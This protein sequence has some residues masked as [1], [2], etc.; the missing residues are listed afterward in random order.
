MESFRFDA[1][2]RTFPITSRR[3]AARAL[4]G[5]A[6]TTALAGIGGG[7]AGVKKRKKKKCKGN[8]K[9][10]GKKCIP[11]SSC[12]SDTG[13]GEATCN[14]GVC[15]CAGLPD[16]TDCGD[17]RQ[18]SGGVCAQRP[19]CSTFNWGT[20][21]VDEDCCTGGCDEEIFLCNACSQAG[22]PCVVTAD[23]CQSAEPLACRGFAC[24]AT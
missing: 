19:A 7:N 23:C 15:D 6:L 2:V 20:C 24:L 11:K 1:L 21:E 12:C 3:V 13:C 22:E 8:K 4:L 14:D 18:C 17:S 10:C 16:L 5:G 9:K